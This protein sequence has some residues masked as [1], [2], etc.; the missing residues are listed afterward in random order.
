MVSE[1]AIDTATCQVHSDSPAIVKPHEWGG[2]EDSDFCYYCGFAKNNQIHGQRIIWNR[3]KP[4]EENMEGQVDNLT[5]KKHDGGKAP[6]AL[7]SSTFIYEVAKVL[8]FGAK[9]YDPWNWKGG[10]KWARVASAVLRHIFS[11]LG[12]EDKDPETGLSHLAH[13]SCGLM[14][15]V[16]FEVNKLGEDD[17]YKGEKRA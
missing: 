1:G 15:L 7:I 12:G 8:E 10:F 2:R 5:G 4:L 6:I 17:R 14:F 13:A 16:D 9:K 11:W 3:L